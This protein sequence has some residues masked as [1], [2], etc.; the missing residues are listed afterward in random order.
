MEDMGFT[1][2]YITTKRKED[3]CMYTLA[4]AVLY[5]IYFIGGQTNKTVFR[6]ARKIHR[7]RKTNLLEYGEECFPREEFEG[8]D[9]EYW[10]ALIHDRWKTWLMMVF[11][12]IIFFVSGIV[13]PD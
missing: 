8:T 6:S 11:L 1:S 5:M 7:R 4:E 2:F 12:I 10:R 9:H 13:C 3:I